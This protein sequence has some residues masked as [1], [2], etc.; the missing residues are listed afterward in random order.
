MSLVTEVAAAVLELR[1]CTEDD[2]A[3]LFP[4]YKRQQIRKALQNGAY[5]KLIR[6]VKRGK[7]RVKGSPVVHAIWGA[8]GETDPAKYIPAPRATQT[9]AVSSVWEL[10]QPKAGITVKGSGTVYRLLGD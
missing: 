10:A 5:R 6:V 1:L 3:P 7:Y 2:L 8:P 4:Q 9:G